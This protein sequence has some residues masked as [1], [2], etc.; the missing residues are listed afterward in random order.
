MK[1]FKKENNFNKNKIINR[2]IKDKLS[3]SYNV[4]LKTSF[5]FVIFQ[6]LMMHFFML[7]LKKE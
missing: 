3:K 5:L 7:K 4:I 1:F 6:I 2:L